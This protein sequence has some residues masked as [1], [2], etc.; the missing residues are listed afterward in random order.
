MDKIALGGGCHWCTE[1]V[2]QSLRGV[3]KVAQ[4]YVSSTGANQ[5]FSEA[6]VVDFNNQEI[7]LQV[8]IEIHL[9]THKSTSQHSRREAYRS[10][11]Y[12]YSL[13]QANIVKSILNQLQFFFDK[14]I[15]TQILPFNEFKPSRESIRNYYK[16]NPQKP[17]CKKYIDPKLELLQ[18]EFFNFVT[19]K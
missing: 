10:A 15:I 17:F 5:S 19:H 8:L 16:K 6:V 7:P 13:E 18:K 11:I 1:A 12:V 9:R 3:K 4:G 2:F 14:P